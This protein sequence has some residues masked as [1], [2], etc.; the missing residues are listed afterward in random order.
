MEPAGRLDARA[1]AEAALLRIEAAGARLA[2]A[3]DGADDQ[4]R[5]RHAQL[6]AEMRSA[7]E[8]IDALIDRLGG[9]R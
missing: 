8:A 1:R 9:A 3:A 5:R 7:L 6:Q 4:L 2:G